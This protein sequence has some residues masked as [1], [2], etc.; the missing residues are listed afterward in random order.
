MPGAA[1]AA[2]NWVGKTFETYYCGKELILTVILSL[3]AK[4]AFIIIYPFAKLTL[5][6]DSGCLLKLQV[7]LVTLLLF[8]KDM[9]GQMPTLPT[10]LRSPLYY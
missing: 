8:L 9:G 1:E 7:V 4:F 10:Q 2:E 3:L 5:L 6:R